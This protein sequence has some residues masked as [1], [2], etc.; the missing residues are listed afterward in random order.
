M[1]CIATIIPTII[2]PIVVSIISFVL[3]IFLTPLRKWGSSEIKEFCIY[4]PH[5]G[6]G[7]PMFGRRM[8]R[9][10]ITITKQFGKTKN[11]NCPHFKSEDTIIKKYNGKKY[12]YCRFGKS[13]NDK[14]DED[15]KCPFY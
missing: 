5:Y 9:Q 15:K 8:E 1:Y 4:Y 7:I 11:I 6:F 13:F 12:L 14:N 10:E 3:I 2:I